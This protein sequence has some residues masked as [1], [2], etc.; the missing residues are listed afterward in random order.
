[1]L[2]S[3]KRYLLQKQYTQ[4]SVLPYLEAGPHDTIHANRDHP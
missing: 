1:M 2:D 3:D 4:V